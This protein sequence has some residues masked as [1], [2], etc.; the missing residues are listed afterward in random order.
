MIGDKYY[1]YDEQELYQ[2][3]LCDDQDCP[4]YVISSP[5]IEQML[6]INERRR[7][8]GFN[9]MCMAFENSFRNVTV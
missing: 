6:E 1:D 4:K 5:S 2:Q 7:I 9:T 3:E 8:S